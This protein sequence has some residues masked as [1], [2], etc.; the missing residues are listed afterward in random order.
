M[1]MAEKLKLVRLRLH[2]LDLPRATF[3]GKNRAALAPTLSTKT[4]Q[5]TQ[6]TAYTE[7]KE[8]R[9]IRFQSRQGMKVCTKNW[10]PQL[11]LQIDS[12]ERGRGRK[13]SLGRLHTQRRAQC[14]ARAH[15]TGTMTRA[16]I[17]SQTLK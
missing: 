15:D 7:D 8:A 9:P 5:N 16:Q 13:R 11:C 14:R 17:R 2:R 12:G 1:T 4:L 10:Q 3:L 6:I